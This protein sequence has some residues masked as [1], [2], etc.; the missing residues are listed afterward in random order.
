MYQFLPLKIKRDKNKSEDIYFIMNSNKR[1][2][3]QSKEQLLQDLKDQNE[4]MHVSKIIT[5]VAIKM[6]EKFP[7]MAKAFLFF[8]SDEDRRIK[9]TEFAKGVEG[10]RVKLTKDDLDQVFDYLDK[11]R[12]QSLNYS[13]FCGLSEEKRRNIDPFEGQ[14]KS[15]INLKPQDMQME[16]FAS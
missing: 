6:E 2:A 14:Q 10:L 4:R 12:D 7:T 1:G 5:L 8:D 15:S 3:P 16:S 9:R 11:D 13:E